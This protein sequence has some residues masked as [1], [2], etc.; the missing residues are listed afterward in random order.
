MGYTNSSLVSKKQ[1]TD[2]CNSRKY[3]ITKITIHHAAGCMSMENL[4]NYISTTS[5]EVSA[6]YVLSGG[7]LGLCVEEKNRAWTSGN[8]ENDHKAVTIEVANSSCGGQWPISDADLAM[9]IKWCADVCKRNNIP[10]LYYDGTPN[11][12]LTLHEMFASTSCP[13]PY[14][15]SKIN[16]ICTE[17]NKLLGSKS[18]ETKPQSSESKKYEVVTNLYGYTTAADAVN[19]KNRKRTV[20]AGT[21]YIYNETSTAVNVTVNKSAPGA[22]ICKAKNVKASSGKKSITDIAKEV[23]AGKWGNGNDRINKLKAAGYNAEGVQAEVNKLLYGTTY[24][25]KSVTEIAKEVIQGK[26]GNGTDRKKRLEAAGY[27]YSE[28]QSAVNK[29]L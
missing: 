28:V 24:D 8:A 13:G 12:S 17:V 5:R 15:K 25:K 6:N 22:W 27:N 21:Y 11:G 23:I 4:L 26:W 20:T 1:L 19:D 3:P 10:K 29:L 7:K 18:A 14:I 2:K 16:Y 9:L